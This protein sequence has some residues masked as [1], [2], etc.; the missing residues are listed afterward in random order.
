MLSEVEH[1]VFERRLDRA[2]E[3]CVLV[4][5]IGET[6]RVS[7]L[8]WNCVFETKPAVVDLEKVLRRKLLFTVRSKSH[9][10]AG[11][12]YFAKDLLRG[13]GKH[14]AETAKRGHLSVIRNQ[15]RAAI[16][17]VFLERYDSR[18]RSMV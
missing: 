12:G 17:S 16:H 6:I 15:P 13:G 14:S 5:P 10:F 1:S 4:L 8:K 2:R 9:H 3:R 11:L 7:K 18:V